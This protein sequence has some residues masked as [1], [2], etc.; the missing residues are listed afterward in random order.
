MKNKRVPVGQYTIENLGDTES[1]YDRIEQL[2]PLIGE[3]VTYFNSLEASLDD[4]ICAAI[5]DRS[6]QKG[7]LVLNS[8]MYATKV[9]LFKKFSDDFLRSYGFDIP[10][11]EE[12]I[13]N[14]KECGTLRNRV[15]HANW[16]RT[17]EDGYT[18][19]RIRVGKE[20]LEHE[21]WQFSG[22]SLLQIMQK[23]IDTYNLLD[24]FDQ[25]CDEKV[26]EWDDGIATKTRKEK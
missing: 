7:L 24:E 16:D 6:D 13:S 17:D 23:I 22:E 4:C 9:D 1:S 25:A 18:Q 15:V 21:L 2:M 14:L 3:I 20:G 11:Y 12:L 10:G 5:S 8:M 19:V 26:S